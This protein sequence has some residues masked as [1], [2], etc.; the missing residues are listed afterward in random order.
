ML[1]KAPD[2]EFKFTA[3]FVYAGP[4]IE[5]NAVLDP[6]RAHRRIPAKTEAVA[7]P[8]RGK[9]IPEVFIGVPRVE[10]QDPFETQFLGD[11]EDIF[12]IETRFRVT[13]GIGD[14]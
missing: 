13:T 5:G 2:R 1:E 3:G 12:G 14:G 4:R 6:Q 9:N 10:E 8:Q 11:G 7:C